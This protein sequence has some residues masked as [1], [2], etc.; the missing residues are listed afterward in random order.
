M[1]LRKGNYFGIEPNAWA[2]REYL[3]TEWPGVDFI[4]VRHIQLSERDDFRFP[5]KIPRIDFANAHSI[6]SH[7]SQAQ[8]ATC[9]ASVHD[10]LKPGGKFFATYLEGDHDYDGDEW[11]YPHCV[12]YTLNTMIRLGASVGFIPKVLDEKSHEQRWILFEKGA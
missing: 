2:L 3:E 7:A 9:L 4:K 12:N 10:Y 5:Y 1:Y 11:V 8:V 6:F